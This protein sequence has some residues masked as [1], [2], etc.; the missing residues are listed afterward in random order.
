[1]DCL[2]NK[3]ENASDKELEKALEYL[4]KVMPDEKT[5]SDKMHTIEVRGDTAYLDNEKILGI[6]SFI[7]WIDSTEV[8]ESIKR[9]R[10][11]LRNNSMINTNE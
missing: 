5:L 3:V 6:H 2:I 4:D 8:K 10:A 7:G 9:Y 11:E 1:M